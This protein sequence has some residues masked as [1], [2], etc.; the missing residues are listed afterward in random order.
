[1]PQDET[2]NL[3]QLLSL[4]EASEQTGYHQDYL[5]FLARTGKLE[6]HKVGR[7]WVTTQGAID[8]LMQQGNGRTEVEDELGNKIPVHV[9]AHDSEK[10][11]EELVNKHEQLAQLK[12]EVLSD[13]ARRV[14]SETVQ[15]AMAENQF[16]KI[17]VDNKIEKLQKNFESKIAEASIAATATTEVLKTVPA[18]K[19]AAPQYNAVKFEKT[20]PTL[21]IT[22]AEKV[23]NKA[24]LDSSFITPKFNVDKIYQTFQH[25]FA[26]AKYLVYSIAAVA[27]VLGGALA[28]NYK[29]TQ[30]Q[31]AGLGTKIANQSNQQ[32]VVVPQ[33]VQEA[34]VEEPKTP[35]KVVQVPGPVLNGGSTKII[36]IQGPRGAQGPT[37]PQGPKGDI[38]LQ[39][40]AATQG[41]P[42]ANQA[43]IYTPQ[44]IP[45]YVPSPSS[46]TTPP[47]TIFS[48]TDLSTTRFN[49][50]TAN[51][52]DL[53]VSGTISGSGNLSV[54]GPLKV[55]SSTA[56]QTQIGYDASD[57]WTSSTDATG[58]TTFAFMGTGSS[59][60]FTP[61]NDQINAF[62]FTKAAGTSVLAVDT[63]NGRVGINNA[64]PT[65]ELD[66]VGAG[67][68]SGALTVNGT[69]NASGATANLAATTINLTGNNPV[70]DNSSP[71]STLFLNTVTN[72]P[73]TFGT[74]NV[75][76]PNLTVDSSV[77]VNG[78]FTLAPAAI[79]KP[80]T[81]STTAFR[82]TKADGT[83]PVLT[84]DSTNNQVVVENVLK[85]SNINTIDNAPITFGTGDV[86]IPNLVVTNSQSSAGTFTIN[87]NATTE[88]ILS[89]IGPNLTSGTAIAKTIT[90]NAGNG[91]ISKGEILTLT[92]ST[93]GGGGYTGIGINITGSGVGS[94]NKYLL[95]LNPGVNTEVVFDNM[96]A[97]RP[98]T[99]VASNTNTI[100]S[101]SF[102]WKNG[103]FDQITANNIAGTVVSGA[104]SSTTWTIGSTQVGDSNEA[105]I[106]QRNSGSGNAAIQW[107]AGAGNLRYLT[108]NYPVNTTYTVT[109][110]SIGTGINLFS[111][112]L[113]NNTTSGTQK[114]LSLTNSGTGTTETGIYLDNSGTGTTGIEIN[115]T[116]TNG[117]ITNN[118]SINAG[119]GTISG[120]S[121]FAGTSV[122]IGTT[123]KLSQLTVKQQADS[124]LTGT[125]SANGSQTI[126]GSSTS[127][128]SRVGIG[129]R[130]A[131]SSSPSTFAT[132]IAITSD[133][134]LT[135]DVPLGNGSS[136]TINLK[137]SLFRLDDNSD[138]T[139]IVVSDL[140]NLGINVNNP[141]SRFQVN[142]PTTADNASAFIATNSTSTKGLVI[143]G[144]SSQTA[145]LF[146]VQKSDGTVGL[147]VAASGNV[148]IGLTN[149][150]EKLQVSGNAYI[151]AQL[152]VGKAPD[153]TDP[154][155]VAH[156][157]FSPSGVTAITVD[158]SGGSPVLQFYR[159]Q[160]T[161]AA[162]TQVTSSSTIGV[163]NAFARSN[164]GSLQKTGSIDFLSDGAVTST[165]SPGFI[166]LLTTP[167]G[168]TTASER[169]RITSTGSV[170]IGATDPGAP[171]E[172]RTNS[173]ALYSA[174]GTVGTEIDITNSNTTNNTGATL[175][176]VLGTTGGAF[177]TVAAI[178]SVFTNHTT[179]NT[180]GELVFTTT[181]NDVRGE[182]MRLSAA[183]SVGI[184]ITNPT[185][186]LHVVSN[187]AIAVNANDTGII[188]RSYNTSASST[189]QFRI[190]H[191]FASV[192]FSNTRGGSS[193]SF[194]T[195]NSGNVGIGITN[196]AAKLDI[197]DTALAGS[198]AL[199]GSALNIA[200]TWSTSG[201][202]TA[203]KLN[204]TDSSSN[205]SSLLLDLQVAGT[206][207]FKVDKLGVV[208]TTSNFIAAGNVAAGTAGQILFQGRTTLTSPAD[209]NLRLTNVAQT[210]FGLLQFG[211]T[212]SSFP[213]I[214]RS[215]TNLQI[216]LA[217]DS[218]FT[219]LQVA[220]IGIGAAPISNAGSFIN[221]TIADTSSS[222]GEFVSPIFTISTATTLNSNYGVKV[223]SRI[224]PTGSGQTTS[225]AAIIG[226]LNFQGANTNSTT[227]GINV[228][229][230][231]EGQLQLTGATS[232]GQINTFNAFRAIQPTN[233]ATTASITLTN[234][235]GLN[236]EN[237]GVFSTATGT[238]ITS[239]AGAVI[240]AQS[241]AT[242]T[243][244]IVIGQGT[245]PSGNF[246][247]YNSSANNNYFAGNV[248]IGT[249][250]P[251]E[252]LDVFGGNAYVRSAYPGTGN[253]PVSRKIFFETLNSNGTRVAGAGLQVNYNRIADTDFSSSLA[254][255]TTNDNVPSEKLRIDTSGNVGIG[256]TNPSATL[257]VAGSKSASAWGTTGIQ[258]AHNAATYTDT[259]SS[260]TVTNA[261]A[262]SLGQPTFAASS[263]T[264][265]TNAANLYIA[266]A[267]A[268]GTNVTLTNPY[269]LYVA[270]GNTFFGGNIG[271]NSNAVATID[272]N[273][274][275]TVA[276]T[277]SS[278]SIYAGPT[279]TISTGTTVS[280]SVVAS[281][282]TVRGTGTGKI[283]SLNSFF[284]TISFQGNNTDS[285]TVGL[286][287]GSSFTGGL[288]L[289]GTTSTGRITNFQGF[290]IS[291]PQNAATTA[292]VSVGTITGGTISNQGSFTVTTGTSIDNAAGLIIAAQSGATNNSAL[293]LGQSTV[294]TGNYGIYNSSANNNYLAGSTG[295]GIT[296]PSVKLHV[297]GGTGTLPTLNTGTT[298]L[299]QNNASSTDRSRI[300]VIGGATGFSVLELGNA[301]VPEAG[302]VQYDNTNNKLQLVSNNIIS[303]TSDASQNIGIGTTSPS[304]KLTVQDGNIGFV[305]GAD[306]SATTLTDATTKAARLGAP[307]YT[308]AEE[309]M[310]IFFAN[311]G[312]NFNNLTIGGGTTL[313]NTATQIDFYTAGNNVT[314]TG[315]SRM[316]I[317]STGNVG[318][319]TT[320]PGTR[321][322]VGSNGASNE[323]ITVKTQGSAKLDLQGDSDNDVGEVGSAYIKLSQDGLGVYTL[324]GTIQGADVG[325]D[326]NAYT[327]VIANSGFLG[328]H[329]SFPLQFGTN[330]SIRMTIDG[331]GNVGIGTTSPTL[332]SGTGL[333]ISNGSGQAAVRLSSN[334]RSFELQ[335][336]GG[337]GFL[338]VKDVTAAAERLRIDSTGN[339]GIGITNPSGLL[340]TQAASGTNNVLLVDQASNNTPSIA[341]RSSASD[342][343]RWNISKQNSAY[344]SPH[345][346]TIDYA[347][348][349]PAL[350]IQT[351]GN[352]GIGTTNPTSKL[353]VASASSTTPF[354][355]LVPGTA[356]SSESAYY[357]ANGRA[358]FGYDGSRGTVVVGDQGT[359]KAIVFD[360]G[361]AIG[362]EVARINNIGQFSLGSTGGGA[363]FS[364]TLKTSLANSSVT[365]S[366]TASSGTVTGSNTQFTDTFKVGDTITAN[367]ETHTITAIASDTSMTTDAWTS[368]FSGVFTQVG[369]LR[370]AVQGNGN[371]FIKGSGSAIATAPMYAG[372]TASGMWLQ[373]NSTTGESN[374][375][376]YSPTGFSYLTLSTNAGSGISAAERLRVDRMGAVGI[377]VTNKLSQLTVKQ[378]ADVTNLGGTTTANASTTITGSS[379]NFTTQVGIGDRIS[380]SSASSTY[381]TVTAIA[382]D[383]SLTVDTALG[384]GTSQTINLKKSL[385][386]LDD[387]SSAVKLV[388]N[389]LGNIGVGV[390]N[391]L[392]KF[393]VGTDVG[394]QTS[395]FGTSVPTQGTTGV[396]LL[397]GKLDS[398]KLI[399]S[400]DAQPLAIN[401]GGN[402]TLLNATAG[403]VGIGTTAPSV[404]LEVQR[405]SD[406]QVL[407][408][409]N[410]NASFSGIA[411]QV[412]T[413]RAA[414]NSFELLRLSSNA[415]TQFSVQGAGQTFI[416]GNLGIGVTNPG[417][418]LEL[419]ANA[420]ANPSLSLTDA[421]VSTGFTQFGITSSEVV[422]L[423]SNSGTVGGGGFYGASDGT[424]PGA[425][426]FGALGTA[427][428]SASIP[429]VSI[430][431]TKRS[432]T[433]FAA[434][435]GTEQVL[436]V[437]T[438]ALGATTKL[439]SVLANGNVGIGVTN[440]SSLLDVRGTVATTFSAS[441]TDGQAGSSTISAFNLSNTDNTFSQILFQ[442]RSSGL[443]VARI[444]AETINGGD[445]VNLHFVTEG[446]G[447][448]ANRMTITSAGNVGIGITDPAFKL[449]VLAAATYS[450]DTT[451]G[452]AVSD[453]TTPAKKIYM[454]F[455]ATLGRGFI[456]AVQSG[457][458][459]KDLLLN[460][461]GANVG[462]GI[463]NPSD[464]LHVQNTAATHII[465]TSN[466]AG[467]TA[468]PVWG[469]LIFQGNAGTEKARIEV[470][471]SSSSNFN[472]D[473]RFLTTI[474]GSQST[475]EKLR[476]TG[477]GNVGIGTT[478]P[479][480]KLTVRSQGSTP[481]FS[482]ERAD[483]TANQ[484]RI[485]SPE[486]TTYTAASGTVSPTWTHTIDGNNS[487]IML[488][489]FNSGGTGG[490]ILLDAANVGIGTTGPTVAKLVV[491]SA[492]QSLTAVEL[493]DTDTFSTTTTYI[494]FANSTGAQAGSIT[495]TGSTTVAY[496]TSSD[497]RLKENIVTTALGLNTLIQIPVNDY[498]F[499]AEPDHTVQG[500]IAQDL[501]NYYPD[502]VK[503]GGANPNTDPW[504]VDYGRLTPLLVKSIQDLNT[505]VVNNFD[506]SAKNFK[507]FTGTGLQPNLVVSSTD[508][509][510]IT[511][512]QADYELNI[513]GIIKSNNNGKYQVT[514]DGVTAL[515][516]TDENG[517][518]TKGDYLTSSA[519]VPGYA[520]K[521]I[522]SGRVIGRA[523]ASF[524]PNDGLG[525]VTATVVN[526]VTIHTA[527]INAEVNVAYA[528]INNTV[529]MGNDPT[530]AQQGSVPQQG[531]MGSV[532]SA[533]TYVIRQAVKTGDNTVADILQLQS[534]NITRLM[535]AQSGATTI[536]ATV[537]NNEGNIFVVRNNDADQ[538][539]ISATGDVTIKASLYISGKLFVTDSQFAG[540][541]ITDGSGNATINF[542]DALPNQ[543][544]VNLTPIAGENAVFATVG[545]FEYNG[546]GNIT[547]VHVKAFNATGT[548]AASIKINYLVVITGGVV[549]HAYTAPA[550]QPLVVQP[551]N[552]GGSSGDNSTPSDA[553]S[554]SSG[555]TVAPDGG[556]GVTDSSAPTPPEPDVTV[557]SAGD[558]TPTN[559]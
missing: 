158:A 138:A 108:A 210:D 322:E 102:Y 482:V 177:K 421:D 523:S 326:G 67:Q 499:I 346:L 58:A 33:P 532:N 224:Q 35:E 460:P 418:T 374:I 407:Y 27:I 297:S 227:V 318:I 273:I 550:S 363:L 286:S 237:M 298:L 203:I 153:P 229:S 416:N 275:K 32:I 393:A 230:G 528:N 113:T 236:V 292:S 19:A 449:Q 63:Q 284:G 364:T 114:L 77:A 518:I 274:Q 189:E 169:L 311:S 494:N 536:N 242:N 45:G 176:F 196:P 305:L 414:T 352:V 280:E 472:G 171:L 456:Q 333:H 24:G 29:A 397:I 465:I 165:S 78:P 187:N 266:N 277:S 436:E 340:H 220:N 308:N 160:G 401:Y 44:P 233:S 181:N 94:G 148:G 473:I 317:L 384:N 466:T 110:A 164:T 370:F 552:G 439:M 441:A 159:S 365:I 85:V 251:V 127:F 88:T 371:L 540:A 80:T 309:P 1:M 188:F 209:G 235:I 295:I 263:A 154:N 37:G 338:S 222:Y 471:D 239:A 559:P 145:N 442:N 502:A 247:I 547:A 468:S 257:H 328:T 555:D 231:I 156:F 495:H 448:P 207:K 345:A 199:A 543:P 476:I 141:A 129:D 289:I 96:G 149:P 373:R 524:D 218:A 525:S 98:T 445:N 408:V 16:E 268:A 87:S 282:P 519:S 405:S 336:G 162:P 7:N 60:V 306:G 535:V 71:A 403:N 91:E 151:T 457:S 506:L 320:A 147:A 18:V 287:N 553:P 137:K 84:L 41:A 38:G 161:L 101:P 95:D 269:A 106:F 62:N 357:G 520:M 170:G 307:H 304:Y 359:S 376:S 119:T 279:Y 351:G 258:S 512:T 146:E 2:K 191:S 112:D 204:V 558:T 368:T 12:T 430:V 21:A 462:I 424:T 554:D 64:A 195:L 205:A 198:G 125:T 381:A 139:K 452:L 238:T 355:R 521:A 348:G 422:R 89:V 301:T 461:N 59:L 360:S 255:Y 531:S 435:S 152:S 92:D 261:V 299:V 26:A 278:Y 467:S 197:T 244:A 253:T 546:A 390:T 526:G 324:L 428:P 323:T 248:G 354:V 303:L 28:L 470:S 510:N 429:A 316:T 193:I 516:V 40:P 105:I 183:G 6:A 69:F 73:V 178:Q 144:A 542:T 254:L 551:S 342:S 469:G 109:D 398:Y 329:G 107:N 36:Y 417:A 444:V 212:T 99:S 179:G 86:T 485:A 55:L 167:S 192:D 226:Q 134:Q 454:G 362:T 395:S 541:V 484:L 419:H 175:G 321:L 504:Q 8:N 252:L 225:T 383:T 270:S 240:A 451:S 372:S 46:P 22:P 56:P 391:P 529:V 404:T 166:R 184:G 267:P 366:V 369:G 79:F 394:I 4:S 501:Y 57:S 432:G 438:G 302:G 557:S 415:V 163:L 51:I 392:V 509:E 48:A 425:N 325:P 538:F 490:K 117:I 155:D 474:S 385:F 215:G 423:I 245:I 455:D 50:V 9:T 505:K 556:S 194:Q 332:E 447:T 548:G 103:Y 70:L 310:A 296:N 537:A 15:Q 140:G 14:A 11:P 294:P 514:T 249:T 410:T 498:N 549:D 104:T 53:S 116:W 396:G 211:G 426:I 283:S 281:A 136:Q 142:T 479:A 375:T 433:S 285:N 180:A 534:G 400:Y 23:S 182:V 344:T 49:A 399:Q 10:Q 219:G 74:G 503:V 314:T 459:Y 358:A 337:S 330:D 128:L 200:Q 115:G 431:G 216:K 293:V 496:N 232:T 488:S 361:N 260:G 173:S 208:T 492:Q 172:V 131:L 511:A 82:F 350:T 143:Q 185:S 533:L 132:V 402:N 135:T 75:T 90:A 223:G 111:G 61:E 544:V 76:V 446:S 507:E 389:D 382:S 443:G 17:K 388:V 413:T 530:L 276:D 313:M 440:P 228:A 265:Y 319:G 20:S 186:A 157:A 250:N 213:A 347:A 5:G 427:T 246:G 13:M 386:R 42:G 234:S 539:T 478:N 378:P 221:N 463:T 515:M 214:K 174:T 315:S 72:N 522:H 66:V 437:A 47:T 327:G 202:P 420:G 130:I 243:S 475:T 434:L 81:N 65:V 126:T 190:S 256:I 409:K 353:E 291:Q 356:L 480:T 545:T 508:T 487:N 493:K 527:I 290:A 497:R 464:I 217:D 513:V 331:T 272:I 380:L 123:Q 477:D 300:T 489:T 93:T 54:S 30:K 25:R 271:V 241:G 120:G 288:N 453:P 97:F 349:S 121:L 486:G 500:F 34:P 343:T 341:L 3:D 52:G 377:G 201:T 206:S 68:F 387:S 43:Y 339:V 379:T 406:G 83:T 411:A 168:S 517:P 450:G 312:S 412:D 259:S 335:S 481:W 483:G 118:N 122:G 100:G 262:N 491:H 31:I 133:T 124:T 367:S 150:T 458:A 39:G 334:T 264:T